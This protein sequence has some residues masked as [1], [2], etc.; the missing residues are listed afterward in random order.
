MQA[1]TAPLVDSRPV[2]TRLRP[3]QAWATRAVCGHWPAPGDIQGITCGVEVHP[4]RAEKYDY[5]TAPEC[6]ERTAKPSTVVSVGVNKSGDQYLI[7]DE[8]T[9]EQ[10]AAGQ[11]HDQRRR[12]YGPAPAA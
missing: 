8:Q 12:S 5:C 10:L 11:H 7:L 2:V 4:E 6:R 1:I 9:R 3:V